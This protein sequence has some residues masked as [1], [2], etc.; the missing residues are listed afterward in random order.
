MKKK[1]T[2]EELYANQLQ[3]SREWKARNKAMVQEYGKLWNEANKEWRKELKK[4][5]DAANVEHRKEYQKE[6]RTRRPDYHKEKHLAY[7]YGMPIADYEKMRM[8]Q[9]S[10]CA[11]C[12]KHESDTHRKR[13]FVDHDHVTGKIRALLCQQCNTALGMVNDD[14]DILFALVGYLEE[15]K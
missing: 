12:G 11:V 13:L 7:A 10:R 5:W 6:F 8:A 4:N 2:S 14:A 3:A 15:H 1:L 9:D